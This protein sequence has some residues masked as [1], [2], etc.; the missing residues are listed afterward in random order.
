M[1]KSSILLAAAV[2]F[3]LGSGCGQYSG[4]NPI[5]TTGGEEGGYGTPPGWMFTFSEGK[6]G[7]VKSMF[8][9]T[10][11]SASGSGE[12]WTFCG[13]ASYVHRG[14]GAGV[15]RGEWSLRGNTLVIDGAPRTF[16]ITSS[17]LTISGGGEV[18]AF[19]KQ[20]RS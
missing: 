15:I 20:L 9:G 17:E 6:D 4:D 13:D 18:S 8:I 12:T 10:W 1:R 14:A 5:G 16:S 11:E 3:L 19:V 2:L 7:P